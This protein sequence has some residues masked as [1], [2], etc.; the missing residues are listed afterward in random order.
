MEDFLLERHHELYPTILD[1]ELPDAFNDWLGNL[2]AEDWMR[3]A[4]EYALELLD[5]KN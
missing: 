4:E 3:Y 2:D 1:D 5:S